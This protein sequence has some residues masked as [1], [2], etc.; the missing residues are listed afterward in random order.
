MAAG[1]RPRRLPSPPPPIDSGTASLTNGNPLPPSSL[2]DELTRDFTATTF[3]VRGERTLLLWHNK[4]GAWLPPGGHIDSGELPEAAALREVLEECGL[5]VEL[6]DTGRSAGVLGSV[7]VLHS[8]WCI[9][10]EDIEP[11]HQHID[12]IYL[13]RTADDAE[14]RIDRREAGRF[15]WCTTADLQGPEI[16]EDIRVLG[17]EAIRLAGAG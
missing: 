7:R 3:V 10:L 4:M 16:A 13:A 9:L 5:T 6:V 8:P 11:G 2:A 1:R 12:L 15:R 17:S 14:P